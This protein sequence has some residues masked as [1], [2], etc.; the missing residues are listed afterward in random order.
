M[1]DLGVAAGN[2]CS[3]A[4]DINSRGMI[5]GSSDDCAG[6]NGNALLW[7]HGDLVN[8]N[9]FVPANSGLRLTVALNINERGAIAAQGVLSDGDTH[10]FVLIPCESERSGEEGCEDEGELTTATNQGNPESSRQNPLGVMNVRLTPE[11]IAARMRARFGR[12]L[13]KTPWVQK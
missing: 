1:A 8:L 6:N 5:V 11:E 9:I 10:A 7:D 4:Y 13:G 2:Q 12:N 3:V